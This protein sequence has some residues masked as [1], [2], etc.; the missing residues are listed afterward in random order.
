MSKKKKK[1]AITKSKKAINQESVKIIW[2]WIVQGAND[3]DLLDACKEKWP[4]TD[5][6]PMIMAALNSIKKSG[7]A[8]PQTIRGW[9]FEAYK[10]LY[11]KS[12]DIGDFANAR[13]C[14]DKIGGIFKG[15]PEE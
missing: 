4:E 13:S 6:M 15:M 2:K 3:S 10:D 9:C 5:P 8:D 12:R 14:V 7:N 1:L 11:F